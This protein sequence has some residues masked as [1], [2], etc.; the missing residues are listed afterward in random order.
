MLCEHFGFNPGELEPQQTRVLLLCKTETIRWA[1]KGGHRAKVQHEENSISLAQDLL[2]SGG[3]AAEERRLEFPAQ[4][5]VLCC[6][7]RPVRP[8]HLS[9]HDPF[10]SNNLSTNR[11]RIASLDAV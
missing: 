10:H 5:I 2:P 9:P 3:T 8:P 1:M 11:P 7:A 6:F 4:L